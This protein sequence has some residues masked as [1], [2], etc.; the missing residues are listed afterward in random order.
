MFGLL[1]CLLTLGSL[2]TPGLVAQVN[3]GDLAYVPM[4]PQ[5]FLIM[6]PSG[7]T[8]LYDLGYV[9]AV[10]PYATQAVLWDPLQPTSF[11]IGGFGFIGRV[12]ITTPSTASYAPITNAIGTVAQLSWHPSGAILVADSGAGQIRLVDPLSGAVVDLT[13]GPQPWG[14]FVQSVG[15]HPG[16]GEIYA[17]GNN[18][19]WRIPG[20]SATP[21]VFASGWAGSTMSSVVSGITF[22]PFTS[23]VVASLSQTPA[24]VVRISPMGLFTD[25]LP[26]PTSGVNAGC[27]A[28]DNDGDFVIGSNGPSLHRVPNV[29]GPA[30]LIGYYPGFGATPQGVSVAGSAGFRIHLRSTGLGGMHAS[31]HYVPSS[32]IEGWTFLSLDVSLPAGTGPVFGI[33]PDLLSYDIFFGNPVATHGNPFHWPWPTPFFPGIPFTVPS[34]TLPTGIPFDFVALAIDAAITITPTPVVRI[35]FN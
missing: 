5:F 28:V 19:I 25:L 17:G 12:T 29:G 3:D 8:T 7:T 13:S 2:A 26:P 22:D 4:Q 20:G 23:E 11:I 1:T 24:R 33:T 32:T 35:T 31:I 10:G 9:Q 14:T 16:T 34:G 18:A 15:I 30:T 21:L 6:S 27:I